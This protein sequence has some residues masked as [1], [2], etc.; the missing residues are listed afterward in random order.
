ME[1]HEYKTMADVENRHWWFQARLVIVRHLLRKH[2]EKGLGLDCS[3]GTGL[4]LSSCPDYVQIGA[5]ISRDALKPSA[6]RGHQQLTQAD[7]TGLPFATGTFDTV[8]SLDTL[9][10]VPDDQAALDELFRVLKP[11]GTGVFTVPAH[12]WMFSSHDR[13]L[14]HQ[15]RYRA[16]EFRQRILAAGFEIR[17]FRAINRN[18][19]P[20][21]ALI[22]LLSKDDGSAK[23]D[24]EGV[25]SW[26]VNK[27]L[28][29]L[30]AMDRWMMWLP[31]PLGVSM[32]AV[33][34]KPKSD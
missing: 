33:V 14:H 5:D 13:A 3:C 22:R 30:F 10:H 11:D 7:L 15:R 12:P 4:T 32:V 21:V 8:T 34:K 20:L 18:L 28:F 31:W 17:L 9:E 2:A 26:P 6:G 16:S 23:S 24:T 19:F 1:S 29:A 25:P 27:A